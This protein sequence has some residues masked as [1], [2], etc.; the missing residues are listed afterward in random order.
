MDHPGSVGPGRSQTEETNPL[1]FA[2]EYCAEFV[3]W[4]GVAFFSR[5]KLLVDD[6]PV[7]PPS[8]CDAV[9]GGLDPP[10]KTGTDNDGTAVT[11]FG[12][13]EHAPVPL[14]ILDWDIDQIEG[15]VL[16]S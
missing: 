8:R 4:S 1:V 2:Q 5:E 10:F 11:F 16:E 14:V 6:Q 15:A 7:P 12:Y 3:D 13:D 9:F